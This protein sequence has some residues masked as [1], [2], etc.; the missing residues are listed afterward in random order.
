MAIDAQGSM[1]KRLYL[2]GALAALSLPACF[3][4]YDSSWGQAKAAQ[5]RLAAS[6]AP[7][8]IGVE[9]ADHGHGHEKHTYRIRLRP[10]AHYLAQTVD[11]ERQLRELVED[12]NR[13]LESGLGLE[14][15]VETIT[16]LDVRRR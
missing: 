3:L 15:E 1:G 11:A 9:T 13:V 14:L 4:G 7:S 5:Q 12:A 2:S 16:A 8:S 6:S 10:N